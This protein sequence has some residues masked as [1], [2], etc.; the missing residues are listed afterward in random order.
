MG[1]NEC[2]QPVSKSSWDSQDFG[3]VNMALKWPIFTSPPGHNELSNK[4]LRSTA[5]AE[6]EV[7]KMT[8]SCVAMQWRKYR[9]NDRCLCF[10]RNRYI[11]VCLK[12]Q[13][14][15]GLLIVDKYRTLA[16]TWKIAK[17]IPRSWSRVGPS[18]AI[19]LNKLCI[20]NVIINYAWDM[21]KQ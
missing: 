17:Q 2:S 19:F 10:S 3:N 7:V 4:W 6:P 16:R 15:V 12:R 5:V 8:I 20:G 14:L 1:T 18:V 21:F 9:Q 13:L 11:P